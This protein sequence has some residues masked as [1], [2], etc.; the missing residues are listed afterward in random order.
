MDDY[1]LA[2][3]K[4]AGALAML[5]LELAIVADCG[6]FEVL[7]G[8]PGGGTDCGAACAADSCLMKQLSTKAR[9]R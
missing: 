2:E 8:S 9:A 3:S 4:A 5:S 1:I 7:Q 6:S